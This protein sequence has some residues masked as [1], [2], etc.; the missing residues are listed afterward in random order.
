[1]E[2]GRES[3]TRIVGSTRRHAHQSWLWYERS[4]QHI[5][6]T[7]WAVH[8]RQSFPATSFLAK[9]YRDFSDIP[10][11]E[12]TE[13]AYFHTGIEETRIRCKKRR[14]KSSKMAVI[15]NLEKQH[16]TTNLTIGSRCALVFSIVPSIFCL[17]HLYYHHLLLF[18]WCEKHSSERR[19]M[20]KK[21]AI[22]NRRLRYY[23][24]PV[25]IEH[26]RLIIN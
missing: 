17:L 25:F 3:M 9:N 26:T 13:L 16:A 11:T 7:L 18:R 22:K 1:M 14:S 4:Y 6:T 21:S 12:W 2:T 23:Y 20:K 5:T 19:K 8:T 10:I 24:Y 15:W